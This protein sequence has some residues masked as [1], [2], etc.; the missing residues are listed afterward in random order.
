M[1][2]VLADEFT[3]AEIRKDGKILEDL[4]VL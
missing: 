4:Q 2:A 3:Y 1:M